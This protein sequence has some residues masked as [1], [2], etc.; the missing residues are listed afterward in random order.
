MKDSIVQFPMLSIIRQVNLVFFIIVTSTSMLSAQ[1][2]DSTPLKTD[3]ALLKADTTNLEDKFIISELEKVQYAKYSENLKKAALQKLLENQQL[4]NASL[5]QKLQNEQLKAESDRKE[6]EAELLKKEA[7]HERETQTRKIKQLQIAELEQ[8]LTLQNRTRNFL[9]AG[10]TLLSL[11]GIS[12]LWS[13]WQL[14]KRNKAIHKLSDEN[15]EK[16]Q[17]KQQILADQNETLEKQV[18]ERTAELN[19]SLTD[20]KQTQNQLIQRS[21]FL[22]LDELILG[23]FEVC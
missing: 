5:Q 22:F 10:V 19:H 23:L 17:E 4:Q 13:N 16:E 3:A 1:A 6:A 7:E 20:L 15:I 9:Y 8:R 2:T 14:K 21:E 12:L 18:T 11:L